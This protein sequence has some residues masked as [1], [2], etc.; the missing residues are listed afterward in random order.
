MLDTEHHMWSSEISFVGPDFDRPT[1]NMVIND[2]GGVSQLRLA[3]SY[4]E[5]TQRFTHEEIHWNTEWSS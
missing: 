4:E 1:F 5:L 2:D 3:L